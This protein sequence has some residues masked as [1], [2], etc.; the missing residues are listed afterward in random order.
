MNKRYCDSLLLKIL[1]SHLANHS[2][3]TSHTHI[4]T[5]IK[6]KDS[7]AKQQLQRKVEENTNEE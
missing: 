3:I 2:A 4:H 5:V 7:E 6:K 1:I